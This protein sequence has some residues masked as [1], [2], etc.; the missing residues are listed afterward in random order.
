MAFFFPFQSWKWGHVNY[1]V[2]TSAEFEHGWEFTF[3]FFEMHLVAGKK[4]FI[5]ALEQKYQKNKLNLTL[6]EDREGTGPFPGKRPVVLSRVVV[7][8]NNLFSRKNLVKWLP[9]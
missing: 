8:C 7:L 2:L 6:G 1:K 9:R 3:Y 5:W 4:D